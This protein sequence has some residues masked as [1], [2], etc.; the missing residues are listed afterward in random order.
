MNVGGSW[1]RARI[2][3]SRTCR[4]HSRPTARLAPYAALWQAAWR[5]NLA[6]EVPRSRM[7]AE[8]T[9]DTTRSLALVMHWRR[10]TFLAP[11]WGQLIL[12]LWMQVGLLAMG[13]R[14]LCS[15]ALRA[16]MRGLS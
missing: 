9:P 10:A 5:G 8:R 13:P 4:R 2:R 15:A 1:P 7:Q 3:L 12:P 14:L 16:V 11:W 6:A